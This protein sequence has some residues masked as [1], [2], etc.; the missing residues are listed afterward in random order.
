LI[1]FNL[2]LCG[3]LMVNESCQVQCMKLKVLILG[4]SG[5]YKCSLARDEINIH[6]D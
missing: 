4:P 6:G 3:S 5:N 2:V 1:G